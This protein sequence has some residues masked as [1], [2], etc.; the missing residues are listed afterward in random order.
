VALTGGLGWSIHLWVGAIVI[1]G[2]IGLF[3]DELG[4]RPGVTAA[5]G[6]AEAGAGSGGGA[7]SVR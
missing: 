7:G 2:I 4:R 3:I 1:A 5:A 6:P